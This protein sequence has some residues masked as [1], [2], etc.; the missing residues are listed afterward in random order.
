MKQLNDGGRLIANMV[1]NDPE[2]KDKH[3]RVWTGDTL[4]AASVYHQ[5]MALPDLTQHGVFYVGANG[6]IGTAVCQKLAQ[7]G[8][9]VTI[10]S[11]YEGVKHPLITYSQDLSDMHAHKYTLIGKLL[12]PS[13]YK[14]VL[15]M[16]TSSPF[17]HRYLFDYTVPFMPLPTGPRVHH[18]QI[19]VLSVTDTSLLKGYYDM[20]FG[21][22]QNHIYPCHMGCL[23]NLMDKKESDEIGDVQLSDMD[24]MWKRATALGLQN[25]AVDVLP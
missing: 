4:T 5:L 8:V 12:R 10:Y 11:T 15:H 14:E 25:K 22:P 21:I 17:G 16:K 23:I 13:T 3:I 9:R 1:A 7:H 6:K 2:L 18:V 19:G 20:C 24:Y